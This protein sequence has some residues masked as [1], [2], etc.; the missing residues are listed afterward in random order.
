MSAAA[1]VAARR[2]T[3]AISGRATTLLRTQD[4]MTSWTCL[5]ET[6]HEIGERGILAPGGDRLERRQGFSIARF[7]REPEV[8]EPPPL[9]RRHVRHRLPH[10]DRGRPAA[11]H[12]PAER[13]EE[14]E[15]GLRFGLGAD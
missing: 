2:Q 6:I 3:A 10:L 14:I 5:A 8:R 15:A 9:L 12:D 11:Q 7:E 1:S 13:A 4:K